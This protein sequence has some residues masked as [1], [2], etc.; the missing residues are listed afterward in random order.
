MRTAECH[1]LATSN[2]A[3]LFLVIDCHIN[4]CWCL[5]QRIQ[6]VSAVDA[7]EPSAGHKFFFSLAP[8][9]THRSNF[10][11]R[12]NGGKQQLTRHSVSNWNFKLYGTDSLFFG[13]SRGTKGGSTFASSVY[14][15][16]RTTSNYYKVEDAR[17]KGIQAS[18]RKYFYVR[19]I[20]FA[21][22]LIQHP[23]PKLFLIQLKHS[24]ISSYKIIWNKSEVMPV[25]HSAM[26]GG[27]Q[28]QWI[29][30][31]YLGVKLCVDMA[32]IIHINMVP[33]LTKTK[34]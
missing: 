32:D 30:I 10:T 2:P 15:I 27:C 28:F 7:D 21:W 13:L 29:I 34:Q 3:N 1:C 5:W 33:L 16:V 18:G 4:G 11:V 20:F 26:V 23:L 14:I 6:T 19:M 24:Q 17:I 25:C 9:G 22:F 31:L 12:D 8:E